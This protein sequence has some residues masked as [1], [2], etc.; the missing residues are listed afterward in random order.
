V[1]QP[2]AVLEKGGL[3]IGLVGLTTQETAIGSSPGPHVTFGDPAM[4]L[5]RSAAV[6][7]PKSPD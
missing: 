5:A 4:A 1:L 6:G 2:H 3:R 7:S